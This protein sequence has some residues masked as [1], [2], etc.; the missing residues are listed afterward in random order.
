MAPKSNTRPRQM[1]VNPVRVRPKGRARTMRQHDPVHLVRFLAAA[2]MLLLACPS[3]VSASRVGVGEDKL[4]AR[5]AVA[6]GELLRSTDELV[7]GV[8]ARTKSQYD[9]Y[10][11]GRAK[12]TPVIDVLVISGGGDWGAFGAG[13]LKGWGEVPADHPLARPEF[14]VVTGVSTGSL[15]APFAFLGDDASIEQVV[16][17]YRN[18]QKDWV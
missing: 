5:R 3:C 10:N 16:H 15:I 18:P 2:T 6:D 12:A 11:A 13:F 4:I 1:P 17:L 14:D 8:L 9:D 7:G